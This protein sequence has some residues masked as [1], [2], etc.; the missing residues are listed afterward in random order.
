MANDEE[1]EHPWLNRSVESA[2]KRVEQR[3]YSVRRYTL[4]YDDVMNQQRMVIYDWRN[5]ILDTENPRAEVFEAIERVMASETEALL[6]GAAADPDAYLDWVNN[7]FPLGLTKADLPFDKSPGEVEKALLQKVTEAYDLKI[8]F[9]Q[10]DAVRHIERSIVLTAIDKLWQE[11]L[12]AMDNLRTGISLYQHAQ[13]DPLIEYK[14]EAYT[15]FKELM[16]TIDAE[17]VNNSFRSASSLVAIEQFLHSL[18]TKMIHD[19][20]GTPFQLS[21]EEGGVA[22]AEQPRPAQLPAPEQKKKTSQGL[23]NPLHQSP[24]QPQQHQSK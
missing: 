3:N 16:D 15:M 4:Q 20:S 6:T 8:K 13:K 21:P 14:K 1:L 2:Q 5:L 11:H 19:L 12:Y 22:T 7:S 9:E 17:I 18:P 23:M 10:E 24:N